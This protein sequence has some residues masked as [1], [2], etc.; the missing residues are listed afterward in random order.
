MPD[1]PARTTKRATLQLLVAGYP[2]HYSDGDVI[3]Q[4]A[5]DPESK[6]EAVDVKDALREL[7]ADRLVRRHG[8]Y[9]AASG[10]AV[11]ATKLLTCV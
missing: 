6:T 7:Q 5:R 10:S 8:R 11:A 1:A 2:A 4:I 3:A 9:W